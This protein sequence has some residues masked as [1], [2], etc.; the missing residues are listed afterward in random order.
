MEAG[1][2]GRELVR[3]MLTFSRKTEQEKKPL[4]LERHR[5]GD[6]QVLAGVHPVDHQH[7]DQR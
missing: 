6:R 3:Q 1:L 4:Q 2:R 5:Q 7:Q